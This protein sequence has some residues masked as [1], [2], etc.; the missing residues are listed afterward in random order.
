MSGKFYLA[1]VAAA[2]IWW[3]VKHGRGAASELSRPKTCDPALLA[4]G[5][6][7]PDQVITYGA[8]AGPEHPAKFGIVAEL[9][10]QD[11]T[12]IT[13]AAYHQAPS[14]YTPAFGPFENQPGAEVIS[15]Q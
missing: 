6:S 2:A 12:A 8:K 11:N 10:P 14:T 1:I 15:L 7:C 9:S 3:Y 13:E 4:P 5:E